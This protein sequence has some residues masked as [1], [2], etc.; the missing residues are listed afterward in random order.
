MLFETETLG[1]ESAGRIA[2][3]WLNG[4]T[5]VEIG[6]AV[7]FA[8]ANPFVEILVVRGAYQSAFD[9]PVYE[10]DDPFEG[11]NVL[12]LLESLPIPTLAYVEGPC[13][14]RGLELALACDYRLAV[15]TPDA[16]F[17][18]GNSPRWGGTARLRALVGRSIDEPLTAREARNVGLV[19]HAFCERR[20]KIELRTWLDRME[21]SPRKRRHSWFARRRAKYWNAI[22]LLAFHRTGRCGSPVRRSH[23]DLAIESMAIRSCPQAVPFAVEF[24]LRGGTVVTDDPEAMEECLTEA[25]V[26]GRIT[27]L[28]WERVRNRVRTQGRAKLAL[29]SESLDPFA[30]VRATLAPHT[31][32]V[33]V[34]LSPFA[35]HP[36]I[37]LTPGTA[38]EVLA[39]LFACIGVESV[40]VPDTPSLAV[41]P[42]LAAFWD[43]AV[44][45]VAEGF[46]IDL[47]DAASGA[48][49]SRPPLRTLDE[50]GMSNVAD[51]VPRVRPFADAGLREAFYHADRPHE[52]NTLA[53]AMLGAGPRLMV[54]EDDIE[55]ASLDAMRGEI[56]RRLRAKLGAMDPAVARAAGFEVGGRDRR[57][58]VRVQSNR[59]VA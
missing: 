43:E 27:P 3:L 37:E 42:L 46:P 49:S 10:R 32:P 18:L 24:A 59:K 2:T 5:I 41:R 40:I 54:N 30:I 38:T 57:N 29:E 58:D 21:D 7:E 50:L 26:R 55:E 4:A 47:V 39:E 44:K 23:S 1:I 36:S 16:W 31:R 34:G 35:N 12:N 14:D 9:V 33:R 48:I 13:H 22:E 6:R 20:A 28:E 45:L 53:Q 11:R 51:L 52:A 15:A 56:E 19:D 17:A 8:C 25:L